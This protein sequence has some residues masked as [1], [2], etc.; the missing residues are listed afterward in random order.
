MKSNRTE[1]IE[2][3]AQGILLIFTG[4]ASVY[5]V[6]LLLTLIKGMVS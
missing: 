6:Y 2:V 3:I 1:L 4:C 5:C